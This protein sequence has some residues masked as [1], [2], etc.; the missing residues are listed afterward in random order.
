[1]SEIREIEFDPLTG[2]K[3]T[4]GFEDGKMKIRYEQQ[5]GQIHD[6]N[7]KLREAPEFAKE[8][9]K[10][11]GQHVLRLTEADCLTMMVED[12][13]NPYTCHPDELLRHVRRNRGKWGHVFLTAGYR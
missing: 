3:T 13:V 11:N 6:M 9:I 4:T 1:M 7:R 8:G 10:N 12:G 2:L 5:T